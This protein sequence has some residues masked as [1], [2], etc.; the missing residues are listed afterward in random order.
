MSE[1][2]NFKTEEAALEQ[3]DAFKFLREQEAKEDHKEP[4][5]IQHHYYATIS[6][7]RTKSSFEC[8]VKY[9]PFIT[10]IF[11]ISIPAGLP[12]FKNQLPDTDLQLWFTA[13]GKVAIKIDD[14]F[15]NKEETHYWLI[16]PQKAK[17]NS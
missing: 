15:Y 3:S 14:R 9:D 8:V 6:Y 11:V 7:V 13:D 4:E 12:K 2:E 17:P 10:L 5:L 16:V 1:I